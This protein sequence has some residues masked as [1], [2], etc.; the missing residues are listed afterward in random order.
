M[1]KYIKNHKIVVVAVIFAILL[2][3]LL[4]VITKT[5]FSGDE[6]ALYG[7]RL[8]GIESVKVTKKEQRD[9]ISKIEDD[10]AVS[11][12][13]YDLQGKIINILI[14]VNNDVGTDTAKALPNKILEVL[15]TDQ[16]KFY[17][18]QVFINKAEKSNDFPIIGYKQ[19]TKDGFSWTK[20]RAAS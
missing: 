3:T 14:T 17:D 15:D 19:N 9:I 12:C 18:I 16:K 5:F 2:L 4:F 11:K 8:D 7:N 6:K 1:I 20:D 13:E 10:S